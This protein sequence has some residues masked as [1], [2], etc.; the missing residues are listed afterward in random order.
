M[1]VWARRASSSPPSTSRRSESS[2]SGWAAIVSVWRVKR[3]IG[4]SAS[5]ATSSP[6]S[7]ATRIPAA[8]ISTSRSSSLDKVCR[9][10]RSGRA[11]SSAPRDADAGRQHPDRGAVHGHVDEVAP[12][13]PRRQLAGAAR[14]RDPRALRWRDIHISV[15]VDQRHHP[16]RSPECRPVVRVEPKPLVRVAELLVGAGALVSAAALRAA[17]RTA[18]RTAGGRPSVQ[19]QAGACHDAPG[20][21]L[22]R[23]V[24]LAREV[25]PG[26]GV[27]R[28]RD[29][30]H[31][32]SHRGS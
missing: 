18:R 31:G 3:A 9:T 12:L 16:R 7:A 20:Q 22:Q 26:S 4:A 10:S 19:R 13:P 5:R 6:R 21:A 30:D 14:H 17:R 32:Q 25:R 27:R 24:Q 1:K 2:R 28:H 29:R 8:A 15:A 11:T 23:L